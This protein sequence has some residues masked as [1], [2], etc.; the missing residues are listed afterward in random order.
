MPRRTAL[1]VAGAAVVAALVPAVAAA[2]PQ[3][4]TAAKP[5]V[6]A[7]A[8]MVT[9]SDARG[10]FEQLLG[11][12][13]VLAVRLM[14]GVVMAR[15]D[16]RTVAE[17][18]LKGNTD[19]LSALVANAY[20]ASQEPAFTKLWQGHVTDLL[21]YANAVAANDPAAKTG[22]RDRLH[23]YAA[24]FGKWFSSAAPSKPSPQAMTEGVTMHVDDLM[25]QIDAYAEDDFATAYRIEREAYEHMFAAADSLSA[26]AQPELAVGAN[27]APEKLRSRFTMLLGE[28]M[29][30]MV[31]STRAAFDNDGEFRAAS[32]ELNGNTTTLTRAIAAVAGAKSAYTFSQIY[33]DHIDALM[34]YTAAS[35]VKDA[36]AKQVAKARIAAV[37]AKLGGYFS[38]VVRGRVSPAA[39]TTAFAMHDEMLVKQID[40]YAAGDYAAAQ[41]ADEEGYLHMI[42][43]AGTLVDGIQGV[44]ASSLP[45]GGAQTGG[46]GM[47]A[48]VR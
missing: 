25:A 16:F 9:A 15:P 38:Q 28:H 18:A 13:T 47:A 11:L 20:G 34:A 14:R 45:R 22:A 24:D 46:G 17:A 40:A 41:R 12:H 35:V 37:P 42:A 5:H 3:P 29:E 19:A 1:L 32:V 31:D 6:H 33:A 43:V 7:A 27:D 8:A 48:V 23:R 36:Q 39:V 26:G 2:T 10:R 44:L 21:A 30:L 4:T